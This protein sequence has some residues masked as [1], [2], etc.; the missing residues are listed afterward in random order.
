MMMTMCWILEDAG[1]PGEL[2]PQPRTKSALTPKT[3]LQ[4][5]R[6]I[7]RHQALG[8]GIVCLLSSHPRQKTAPVEFDANFLGWS[9]RS[10]RSHA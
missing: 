9:I 7:P 4:L 3:I 6:S 8:Q 2:P 5:K 1:D 10:L